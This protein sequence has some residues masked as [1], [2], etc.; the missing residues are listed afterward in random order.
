[1]KQPSAIGEY[2]HETY[3]WAKQEVSI[4]LEPYI[5]IIGELKNKTV[6]DIGCGT[7]WLTKIIADKA[8]KVLG[9]DISKGMIQRARK[10]SVCKNVNYSVMNAENIDSLNEK[11]DIIVSSLTL[12]AISPINNL[13]NVLTKAKNLL[14]D[15]GKLI[16]LVPHPCFAHLNSRPYNTYK[17]REDFN[18]FKKDQIYDVKLISDKGTNKFS[19]PFYSL[20]GYFDAFSEAGLFIEKIMEPPVPDNLSE[21]KEYGWNLELKYPFYIIFKLTKR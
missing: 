16:I 1:M 14:R 7:G 11:F 10:E 18:Y 15:D 8:K 19:C 2:P 21:S 5:N 12:H 4:L 3:G 13:I 20:Q 17:F 6:L 9:I